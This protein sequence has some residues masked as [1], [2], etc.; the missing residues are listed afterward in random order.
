MRT[1]EEIRLLVTEGVRLYNS[2]AP[3]DRRIV[4]IELFGSYAAGTQTA[5]SDIDLLVEF[6]TE[7]VS[8]FN[9]AAALQAME[10]ATGMPVDLV[11]L[12][13]PEGS[14]LELERTVSLYEA[15]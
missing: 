14:L 9:L 3:R 8:L 7:R 5:D 13:L 4:R 10:D 15:A 12:P 11:Q 6:A 2:D 1:L